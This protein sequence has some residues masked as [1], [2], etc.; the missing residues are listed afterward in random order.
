MDLFND[1][2]PASAFKALNRQHPNHKPLEPKRQGLQMAAAVPLPVW[3]EK[4][5]NG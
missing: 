3:P 1:S 5:V 4:I 2:R